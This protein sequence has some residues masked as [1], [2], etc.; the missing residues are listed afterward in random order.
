MTMLMPSVVA[1]RTT[2]G[3]SVGFFR[4]LGRSAHAFA[5]YW[6]RRSAIRVLRERDDRELRDIGIVRSQ[7]ETAVNGGFNAEWRR[8]RYHAVGRERLD[9]PGSASDRHLEN[10]SA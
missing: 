1:R 6:E 3:I 5:A 9:E 2:S 4:W 10:R 8:V 7:I